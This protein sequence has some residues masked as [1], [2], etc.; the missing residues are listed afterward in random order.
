MSD[1]IEEMA[2]RL[3]KRCRNLN[4]LFRNKSGNATWLWEDFYEDFN[5][6]CGIEVNRPEL[7]SEKDRNHPLRKGFAK[8]MR[9]IIL[10]KDYSAEQVEAHKSELVEAI[11]KMGG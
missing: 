5:K 6:D 2:E 11:L 10:K 8:A 1:R 4:L 3:A 7:D 9:A